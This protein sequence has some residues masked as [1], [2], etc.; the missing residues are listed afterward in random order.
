MA[1]QLLKGKCEGNKNGGINLGPLEQHW[2]CRRIQRNEEMEKTI[3]EWLRMKGPN[4]S[5][6][7]EFFIFY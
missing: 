4:I 3:C 7:T 2:L 5:S 6:L 1:V